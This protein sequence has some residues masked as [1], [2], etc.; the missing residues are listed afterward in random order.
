MSYSSF[1]FTLSRTILKLRYKRSSYRRT[2]LKKVG[3]YTRKMTDRGR[4]R[5]KYKEKRGD[6]KILK[7]KIK[8]FNT[9]VLRK[10]QIL[11]GKICCIKIYM[12]H[13]TLVFASSDSGIVKSAFETGG[14]HLKSIKQCQSALHLN[15]KPRVDLFSPAPNVTQ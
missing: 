7:Q 11:L 15:E 13:L 14:C 1:C 10:S 5:D 6:T 3:L 8:R 2:G 12:L 9:L 4:Q